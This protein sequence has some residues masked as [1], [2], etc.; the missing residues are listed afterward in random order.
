[1]SKSL[2]LFAAVI[3]SVV[4]A[5][6]AAGLHQSAG[7]G[8]VAALKQKL[9]AGANINESALWGTPL[10]YASWY[11]KPEAV[12]YLL[13]KGADLEVSRS[14]PN[15][16][17][18]LHLAIY[19]NCIEAVRLLVEAG[20]DVNAKPDSAHGSPLLIAVSENRDQIAK[21]LIAH[22]A[23]L[24]EAITLSRS[25]VDSAK[26]TPILVGY[27]QEAIVEAARKAAQEKAEKEQARIREIEKADLVEL[28]KM[29]P[30][31]G[32]QV[33]TLTQALIGAKNTQLPPFMASSSVDERINLLT[34]VEL[35]ISDAQ[36]LMARLNAMAED[37]VRQGKSAAPLREE[38]GK[39]QTYSGLLNAIRSMLLQ[40]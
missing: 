37:A 2:T 3:A 31:T 4:L 28:L 12:S 33:E 5:G 25:A 26:V 27:R 32:V 24:E 29:R 14:F 23:D 30:E 13:E 35:R 19:G 17:R 21:Y 1:M 36:T 15:G 38:A 34:T 16:Y 8:D 7:Q 10:A 40:S 20:A 11:C 6:C 39:V 9:S 22:G 18:P